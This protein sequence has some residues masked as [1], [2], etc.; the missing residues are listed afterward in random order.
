MPRPGFDAV[1]KKGHCTAQTPPFSGG[2]QFIVYL[3]S[4]L[5]DPVTIFINGVRILVVFSGIPTSRV[6]GQTKILKVYSL[7]PGV[8]ID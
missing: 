2:L 1:L 7:F 3:T 5:I 8:N 6:E 4:K